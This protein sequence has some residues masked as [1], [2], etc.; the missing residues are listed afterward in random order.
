MG[1]LIIIIMLLL[2]PVTGKE[3]KEVAN[4]KIWKLRVV[5]DSDSSG[6][7]GGQSSIVEWGLVS[8]IYG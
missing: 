7:S 4:C 5:L 2:L 1:N 8:I 6:G 3:D